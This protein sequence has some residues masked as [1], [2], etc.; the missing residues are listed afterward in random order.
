M[1]KLI[2]GIMEFRKQRR[3]DYA[4]TFAKL[5]L[6]QNPDVLFI[7]CSDSRVAVN[8]F[9]STDPGDMFVV[10]NVGNLIPPC[11]VDGRSLADERSARVDRRDVHQARHRLE[12]LGP[13]RREE[14]RRGKL[15]RLRMH[16]RIKRRWRRG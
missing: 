4:E 6:G 10:R 16:S 11:D 1:R 2:Q 8:V 14:R 13:Q 12:L 15:L 7:A 3:S 9:A 5:A